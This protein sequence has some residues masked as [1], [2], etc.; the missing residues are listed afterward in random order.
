MSLEESPSPLADAPRYMVLRISQ[1][2][3]LGGPVQA[4]H[5]RCASAFDVG[6]PAR[7]PQ[8]DMAATRAVA[9]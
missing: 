6:S 8:P 9:V 1:E 7:A 3:Q 5:A 2:Y 4:L